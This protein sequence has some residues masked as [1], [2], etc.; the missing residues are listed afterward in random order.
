MHEPALRPHAY[1]NG[2]TTREPLPPWCSPPGIFRV[3]PIAASH[4][5]IDWEWVEGLKSG[6]HLCGLTVF[7]E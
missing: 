5:F 6:M 4:P 7:I 2:A 3:G 1:V